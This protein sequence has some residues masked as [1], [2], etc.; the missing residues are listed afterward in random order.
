MRLAQESQLLW[1][2]GVISLWELCFSCDFMDWRILQDCIKVAEIQTTG[3][4]FKEEKDENVKFTER[5]Q[6]EP[7]N[8]FQCSLEIGKT[9]KK[10]WKGLMGWGG[11]RL[12]RCKGLTSS[13]RALGSR[14]LQ[15]QVSTMV[16][17]V[18][19][20]INLHCGWL[21]CTE[22]SFGL[23]PCWWAPGLVTPVGPRRS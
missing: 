15:N 20:N 4:F 22:S 21:H 23:E 14:V 9:L 6:K 5:V 19:A 1:H 7:K 3:V 10:Y 12:C 17:L 11:L 2:R 8:L 16:P 18:W 13:S